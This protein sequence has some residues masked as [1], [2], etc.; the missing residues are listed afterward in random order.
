MTS[1]S[2]H[3]ID[4]LTSYEKEADIDNKLKNYLKINV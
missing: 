4:N 3:Y 1:N 2:F